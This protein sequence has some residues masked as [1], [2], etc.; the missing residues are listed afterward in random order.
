[1]TMIPDPVALDV[2]EFDVEA[3]RADYLAHCHG[4]PRPWLAA[5]GVF[6]LVLALLD[7]ARHLTYWYLLL[8][9]VAYI[10]FSTRAG[11]D[12][13]TAV[14]PSGVRFSA[15][16]IDV[17]VPFVKDPRRHYSWR[18]IRRIDDIGEA[19]VLVPTFGHRVILPK[20][21]F[22]DGG[23]EAWAFFVANRVAG[24]TPLALA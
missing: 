2:N 14:R 23:H 18:G 12:F 7:W 20:R 5:I 17:D 6:F 10:A 22:P 24:R 19:F 4:V 13:P 1:M 8:F 9:G 15:E 11:K 3:M 21:S 16:G